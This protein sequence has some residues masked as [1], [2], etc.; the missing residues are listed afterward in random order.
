MITTGPP[1]YQQDPAKFAF[2]YG[3]V[4]VRAKI[5]SGQG[6]LSAFWLL[7][8]DFTSKPSIDAAIILGNAPDTMNMAL[9]YQDANETSQEVLG[10]LTGP[11]LSEDWHIYGLEWTP[12]TL[13]WSVD[14][15]ERWRFEEQ[16]SIPAT[17]LYMLF[18]LAV[19]GNRPGAPD[20]ALFTIDYSIDYV[21]VWQRPGN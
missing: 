20:P 3:Y 7:P 13:I 16:A 5:P 17:S 2:R 1:N 9:Y 8:D 11:D 18:N 4:E 19:G 6:L 14:G 12:E 15:V 10:T 21:R